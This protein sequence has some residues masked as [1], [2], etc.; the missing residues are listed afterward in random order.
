[1]VSVNAPGKDKEIVDLDLQLRKSKKDSLTWQKH[2]E[3]AFKSKGLESYLTTVTFCL[4]Y[5][6]NSTAYSTMFLKSLSGSDQAWLAEELERETNSA[7]VWRRIC[8]EQRSPTET[9]D[10]T[11]KLW[12]ALLGNKCASHLDFPRFYN[13]FRLQLS[14]L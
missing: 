9:I 13:D 14:K 11:L 6:N 4:T 7:K 10:K 1:M 3:Q 8:S 2:V 5:V 12:S